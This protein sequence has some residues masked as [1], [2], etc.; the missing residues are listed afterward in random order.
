MSNRLKKK[1]ILCFLSIGKKVS[2]LWIYFQL[3]LFT[4]ISETLYNLAFSLSSFSFLYECQ[5]LSPIKG[6][7]NHVSLALEQSHR[8]LSEVKEFPRDRDWKAE[9]L[10]SCLA[11]LLF[12]VGEHPTMIPPVLFCLKESMTLLILVTYTNHWCHDFS[13]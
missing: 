13:A 1:I 7:K 4:I 6:E 10:I 2:F 3:E 5:P 8:E 9:T 11:L 12:V